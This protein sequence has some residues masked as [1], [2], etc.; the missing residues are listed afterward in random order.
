MIQLNDQTTTQATPV[1]KHQRIGEKAVLAIIRTERRDRKKTDP[2]TGELVSIPNGVDRANRP[3]FKQELVVHCLVMPG[4]TMEAAIGDNRGVPKV[5]DRVR[6]IVKGKGYS[7]WIDACR[8]HRNGAALQ[9][10]DVL[11]METTHAQQYD[12]DGR[13]KGDPILTQEQADQVARNITLGFYGSI[14]LQENR[15]QLYIEGA[16]EAYNN[17]QQRIALPTDA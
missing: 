11:L 4:T 7:E 8:F 2:F 6:C 16:E 14:K 10:G 1:I 13:P 12:Q 17:D 3:K 9:V 15:E 5:G